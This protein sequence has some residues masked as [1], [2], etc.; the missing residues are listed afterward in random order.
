MASVEEDPEHSHALWSQSRLGR[1]LAEASLR[2]EGRLVPVDP[3][4]LTCAGEGAGRRR[5][6]VRVWAH[7]SC[8]QPTF[9]HGAVVGPD[10]LFRV[11][12]TGRTRFVVTDAR[13]SRY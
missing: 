13:F 1:V 5:G 2:V 10:A 11:H 6:D 3:A 7:F 8:I 9:P 4:T 12:A